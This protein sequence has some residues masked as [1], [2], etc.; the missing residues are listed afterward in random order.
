MDQTFQPV[1]TEARRVRALHQA[2]ASRTDKTQAVDIVVHV[3][4]GLDE[5]QRLDLT[6]VLKATSGIMDAEFCASHEHLMLV[7]YDTDALSSQEILEDI[8]SQGVHAQLIG[9]V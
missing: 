7:R 3:T 1:D 9:P 2:Q 6:A 5:D 4:E 8:T